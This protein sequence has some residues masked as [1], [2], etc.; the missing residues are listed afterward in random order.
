MSASVVTVSMDDP[1]YRVKEI[2][3]RHGFHHLL[4]VENGTLVGVISDRD[5]LRSLSPHLGTASETTRDLAT[6]N[7]RAHQIMSRGLVTLTETAS[8]EQAV[9]ALTE[10]EISCLPI[11]D[12]ANHPV[13]IVSWRDI[14]KAVR[15]RR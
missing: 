6:L 11:V 9:E 13:G 10:H 7:K 15:R 2:F 12:A 8:I 3:D 4:V 14:L 1:L 5:L